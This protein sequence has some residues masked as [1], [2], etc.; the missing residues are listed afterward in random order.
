M[1]T[2]VLCGNTVG[3]VNDIAEILLQTDAFDVL[4]VEEGLEKGIAAAVKEKAELLVVNLSDLKDNLHVNLLR[5]QSEHPEIPVLMLGTT[6][7]YTEFLAKYLG[8]PLAQLPRPLETEQTFETMA[9]AMMLE[10]E[11][12]EALIRKT[13]APVFDGRPKVLLVDDNAMTLRSMKA[14]LDREY[15]VYL[16]TSGENALALMK[17]HI[18]DVVLLDYEMPGMNGKEVLE[19]IRRDRVLSHLRVIFLTGISDKDQIR[20]VMKLKPEGYLLKP[21]EKEQLDAAIRATFLGK[22]ANEGVQ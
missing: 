2:V 21:I 11:E 19:R 9:R 17:K 6:L 18:P 4:V 1:R 15:K 7:E 5:V 22:K 13:S 12:T 8:V 14:L 16:A 20:A 10:D 3:I